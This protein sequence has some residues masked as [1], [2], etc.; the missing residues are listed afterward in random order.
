MR[1]EAHKHLGAAESELEEDSLP[2]DLVL[3]APTAGLGWWKKDNN[4]CYYEAA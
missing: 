3:S 1:L 2:L 4:A